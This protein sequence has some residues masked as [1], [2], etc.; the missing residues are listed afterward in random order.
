MAKPQKPLLLLDRDGSLIEEGDYL[1]DPKQVTL[2]PGVPAALRALRS[3]GFKMVVITNQSGIARGRITLKQL[4]QVNRRFL[5]LLKAKK[6]GVD[7]LYWCPHLPSAQCA[8]RKP[9][10]ALVKRAARRLKRSWRGCISIGD[11]PSDILLGQR[12]GGKGILV[13][14]GY[15]HFWQKRLGRVRPDHT[16][17]DFARAAQWILCRYERK[18]R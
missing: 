3:A 1:A 5:E 2:L 11:R 18:T 9:K 10:L 15:G 17:R 14:S 8:C 6:T 4:Q 12:T 7:G 16:S 13:L